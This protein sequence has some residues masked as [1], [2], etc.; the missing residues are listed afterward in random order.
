MDTDVLLTL[1]GVGIPIVIGL[2]LLLRELALWFYKINR[3]VKLMIEQNKLLEEVRD[4]LKGMRPVCPLEAGTGSDVPVA[5][6]TEPEVPVEEETEP[7]DSVEG[8]LNTTT[9]EG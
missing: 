1:I 3:I 2:L 5:E 9:S 4:N 7:D 6:E 8:H